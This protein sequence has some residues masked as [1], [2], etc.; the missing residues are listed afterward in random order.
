MEL[1][2]QRESDLLSIVDIAE[3]IP[4]MSMESVG[5]RVRIPVQCFS[6]LGQLLHLSEPSFLPLF[7]SDNKAFLL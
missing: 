5:S 3:A 2:K 7:M 4:V 1:L 6:S